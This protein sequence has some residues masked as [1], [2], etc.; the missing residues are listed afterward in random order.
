MQTGRRGEEAAC[1]YLRRLGHT[2]VERNW[3]SGHLEVDIITLAA[4]GLHFVEVKTRIA[5]FASA[6]EESVT[7]TK[8]RKIVNAAR[9]YLHS[10]E[11]K[12]I[13]CD[14]ELF[15]DVISV[16]FA[17][18]DVEVQYFPQAYIPIYT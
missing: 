17:G 6:P 2:I 3:R 5:P 13:Y 7:A 10:D 11:K 18:E 1:E 15:F 12:H 14:A 4:D 9:R 8:Q 16:I